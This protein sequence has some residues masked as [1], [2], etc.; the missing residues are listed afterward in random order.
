[1]Q[2]Y[3]GLPR[4]C[5]EL[6]RSRLLTN[7]ISIFAMT[8]DADDISHMNKTLAFDIYGTLIDTH[9]VLN[10]LESLVG[11]VAGEF[12]ADIQARA[13]GILVA[14]AQTGSFSVNRVTSCRRHQTHGLSRSL[15]EV[16]QYRPPKIYGQ[17]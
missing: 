1:M 4:A 13:Q 2:H 8:S 11:G 6:T 10:R 14:P 5:G 3:P 7:A 17:P 16:F 15:H 12:F 9:G